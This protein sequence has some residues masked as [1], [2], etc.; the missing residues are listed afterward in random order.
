MANTSNIFLK[1]FS[2]I[3]GEAIVVTRIEDI[4]ASADMKP[5][6]NQYSD[7]KNTVGDQSR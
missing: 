7:C 6:I 3:F 2:N 4:L 5:A 1:Q